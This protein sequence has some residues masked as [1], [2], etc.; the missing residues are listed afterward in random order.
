MATAKPIKGRYQLTIREQLR[1]A[2]SLNRGTAF[3]LVAT[4]VFIVLAVL[5]LVDGTYVLAAIE[6]ALA[7][8]MYS[9]YYCLPFAWFTLRRHR[10]AAEAP[11]DVLVN[12]EG[13]E[14]TNAGVR[15]E[16]PWVRIASVRETPTAFF[17]I[18]R[19]PRAFLLPKRAF[20]KSQLAAFRKLAASVTRFRPA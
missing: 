12:A 8:A 15:M 20:D 18:S 16:L 4:G 2:P 10:A 3:G 19:Y 11:V 5:S 13:L 1:F 6:L 7:A 17:L 14:F 9:G